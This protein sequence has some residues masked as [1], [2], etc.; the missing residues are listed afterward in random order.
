MES[1]EDSI[2]FR[3]TIGAVTALAEQNRIP[4]P[5]PSTQAR[6]RK[7]ISTD[8]LADT[9]SDCLNE[10]SSDEYLGNGLSRLTLRKFRRS[11]VQSSLDL[12]GYAVDE[13][14]IQL[15][16]FLLEAVQSKLRC[17][18]VI[19]GKGRNS[20]GGESV[21]RTLTR[22]WLMQHPQVLAFCPASAHAGGSGAVMILLKIRP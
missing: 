3:A 12:H 11:A 22:N 8:I 13:A 19:H 20:P 21:L 7:A 9:L 6:V 2:L 15:Q 16:A 4:P 18:Q 14:R 5:R 10:N 17:V 1:E